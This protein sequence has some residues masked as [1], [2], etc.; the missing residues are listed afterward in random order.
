MAEKNLKSSLKKKYEKLPDIT[1]N[2]GNLIVLIML[3]LY[4][5]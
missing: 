2:N 4:V 3:N 5:C 1:F